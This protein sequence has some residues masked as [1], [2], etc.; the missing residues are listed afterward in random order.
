MNDLQK[1]IASISGT[2]GVYA[3]Q[4]ESNFQISINGDCYFPMAS[5][6]KVPIAAYCLKLSEDHLIDFDHRV[7]VMPEDLRGGSGIIA[8][9]F[10]TPGVSL[11]IKNLIRLMIEDSDNTASDLIL[12]MCGGPKKVSDFLSEHNITGMRIDST[13]LEF[14]EN[15]EN[16]IFQSDKDITTPKAMVN[17]LI[18]LQRGQIISQKSFEFLF[19]CMKHCR[20]G[21]NRIKAGLPSTT[22]VG[23]KTGTMTGI[24]NDVGIIQ[25]PNT[26]GFLMIAIF[27]KESE[28]STNER[29]HLI[30]QITRIIYDHIHT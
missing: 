3:A 27:I 19:E 25:M 26:Q 17:L 28:S 13:I 20:T 16:P 2:V 10:T 18:A 21:L 7:D 30:A 29:E 24:T 15:Y 23:Q 9:H 1:I 11:S 14:F 4:E 6:Y 5:T 8:S 22:I 12:T